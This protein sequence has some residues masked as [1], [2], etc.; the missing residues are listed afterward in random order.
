MTKTSRIPYRFL[1]QHPAH[2]IA[3]GFGT[4][5]LRPASGTW[6]TL[7]AIPIAWLSQQYPTAS[8]IT[9][10]LLLIVGAWAAQITGKHLDE[11][12]HSGI[13]IDEIAAFTIVLFVTGVTPI[14]VLIAFVL[15]RFFDIV[16]PLPIRNIDRLMRNGMGV[17]L[18]DLLAAVY[19]LLAFIALNHFFNF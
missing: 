9:I 3:L 13:V 10:I 1:F 17:M 19:T 11:H 4:G 2:F 12:D 16:K 6:G 18:D 5:L 8:I 14:T 7:P 15:F